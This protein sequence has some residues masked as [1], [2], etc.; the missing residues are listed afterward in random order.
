VTNREINDEIS[1]NEFEHAQAEVATPPWDTVIVILM[2]CRSY[3]SL[4]K[5]TK[6][7]RSV[8]AFYTASPLFNRG[9]IPQYLP[10][11]TVSKLDHE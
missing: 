9:C 8:I 6:P 1:L 7:L 4:N 11:P 5:I 3:K 10:N 2:K